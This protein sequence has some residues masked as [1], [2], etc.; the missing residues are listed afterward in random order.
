MTTTIRFINE[1]DRRETGPFHNERTLSGTINEAKEE[2]K[3]FAET[4][5][6]ILQSETR[7]KMAIIKSSAPMMIGGGILAL[8]GFFALTAAL[9]CV[10]YAVFAPS[11]WAP[12]LGCLIVGA[13]YAIIG[14]LALLVGYQRISSKGLVPQRTIQVLKDDKTWIQNE[15]RTQL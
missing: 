2:L 6:A 9:I 8:T 3:R 5:L 10:V 12:F 15:A 7:E 4:R 11:P 14:G 13:A 1:R